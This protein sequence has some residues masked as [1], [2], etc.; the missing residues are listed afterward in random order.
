MDPLVAM[1][2]RAA[3]DPSVDLERMERLMQM[4]ERGALRQAEGEFNDAM[5]LVQQ[6]LAP[7]AR[8]CNNPSCCWIGWTGRCPVSCSIA[9]LARWQS[10]QITSL[11]APTSRR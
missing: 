8:D 3:R 5:A 7:I 6:E 2:E 1:I 11:A 4:Q 10:P 9:P